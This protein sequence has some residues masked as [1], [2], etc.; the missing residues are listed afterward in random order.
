MNRSDVI[1]TLSDVAREQAGYVTS[2]QARELGLKAPDLVRLADQGDLRRVAQGVYALPGVF[3]SPREPTI[4]AWLRLL[5]PR[6]PWVPAPPAAVASHTTAAALRNLGTLQ[7]DV[8]TYTVARRR[9]QPNDDS[10]QLHVTILDTPDW[11]WVD[12]PEGIRIPVTTPART[13]VDLAW[14]GEDHDHVLDALD[15]ALSQ[16]LTTP[17]ELGKRS[18]AAAAAVVAAAPGSPRP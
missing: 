10:L 4:A 11:E 5:G 9:Y 3:P 17:D 16:E 7:D 15:D 18:I 1:R 14:A 2:A 12:L 8:P 6:L 13:I